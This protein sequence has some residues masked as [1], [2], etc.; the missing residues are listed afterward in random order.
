[1]K[2]KFKKYWG[3]IDCFCYF[4][5]LKLYIVEI[6]IGILYANNG[7]VDDQKKILKYSLAK[8]YVQY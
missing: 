4:S 6:Y 5:K 2:C 3:D 7:K 8:I 1:M